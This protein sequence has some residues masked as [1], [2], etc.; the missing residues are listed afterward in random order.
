MTRTLSLFGFLK[1]DVSGN[2]NLD[3]II[4]PKWNTPD[5]TGEDLSDLLDFVQPS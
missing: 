3:T 5:A 1:I 2:I 4:L